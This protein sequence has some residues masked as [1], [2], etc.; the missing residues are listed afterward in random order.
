MSLPYAFANVSASSTDAALVSAV[1]GKSIRVLGLV[2][3]AGATATNVTFN[4]KPAGSGAAVSMLFACS[5]NGGAVLPT[6]GNGWF[7]TLAGEGLTVTT[8]AGSTVG[9]QLVW[10]TA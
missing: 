9:I 1:A 4:S 2:V 7:Q 8:G 6:N 3:I 10:T 5:A